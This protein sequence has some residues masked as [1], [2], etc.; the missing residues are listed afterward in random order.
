MRI[1]EFLNFL[2]DAFSAALA[3]MDWVCGL[4]KG[5]RNF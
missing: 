3:T 1:V 5:K 2:K 4:D